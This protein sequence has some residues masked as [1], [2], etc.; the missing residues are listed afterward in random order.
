MDRPPDPI[1]EAIESVNLEKQENI[2]SEIHAPT[3]LNEKKI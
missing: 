1:K 3:E 2:R